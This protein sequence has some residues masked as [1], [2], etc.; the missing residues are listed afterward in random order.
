[1]SN[2]SGAPDGKRRGELVVMFAVLRLLM[3]AP[4]CKLRIFLRLE[5]SVDR[6]F[7]FYF[8]RTLQLSRAAFVP[9]RLCMPLLVLMAAS[10]LLV[11]PFCSSSVAPPV[12]RPRLAKV[13]KTVYGSMTCLSEKPR[14]P[15]FARRCYTSLTYSNV[16]SEELLSSR[17]S[18]FGPFPYCSRERS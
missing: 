2:E 8:P 5:V 1:M 6:R 18:R 11:Y 17:P 15:C 7:R 13:V 3:I 4:C 12:T 10:V 9:L 16:E 14:R